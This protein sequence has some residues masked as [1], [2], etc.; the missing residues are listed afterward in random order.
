MLSYIE[1]VTNQLGAGHCLSY[2]CP[3]VRLPLHPPPAPLTDKR[4]SP[5]QTRAR[6][7][8]PRRAA[9]RLLVL[10]EPRK[11]DKLVASPTF[12]FYYPDVSGSL[13]DC[14]RVRLSVAPFKG[15]A[16]KRYRRWRAPAASAQ[17][18][19]QHAGGGPGV[20]GDAGREL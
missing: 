17:P 6:N 10:N 9:G 13:C 20:Q 18:P 7:P 5:S 2:E 16:G 19:G 1:Q 14:V 4:P 12:A 3:A 15:T 8:S 11:A